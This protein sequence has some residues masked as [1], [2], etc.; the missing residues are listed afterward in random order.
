MGK[1]FP[2]LSVN[3]APLVPFRHTLKQKKE[4]LLCPVILKTAFGTAAAAATA[5]TGHGAAAGATTDM[6]TAM[7]IGGT[8]DE[9]TGA[10][11]DATTG[12]TIGA[13][14]RQNNQHW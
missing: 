13:G 3:S 4:N 6:M 10:M 12:A 2:L 1:E 8:T 7:M 11:T 14:D 9:A 5:E